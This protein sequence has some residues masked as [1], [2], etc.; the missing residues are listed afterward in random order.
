MHKID[1]HSARMRLWCGN[2]LMNPGEPADGRFL[3]RFVPE[4]TMV[5]NTN[6]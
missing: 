4:L 6:L 1:I 2:R 3:P 5:S